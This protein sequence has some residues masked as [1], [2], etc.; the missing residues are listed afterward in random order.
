MAYPMPFYAITRL[1]M[2]NAGFPTIAFR[3]SAEDF[4]LLFLIF[5]ALFALFAARGIFHLYGKILRRKYVLRT[6]EGKAARFGCVP[7]VVAFVIV[8]YGAQFT[9]PWIKAGAG[10]HG[11]WIYAAAIGIIAFFPVVYVVA[12]WFSRRVDISALQTGM[13]P[14]DAV[15]SETKRG[16]EIK[17]TEPA[18]IARIEPGA[19]LLVEI[20]AFYSAE[21][22]YPPRPAAVYGFGHAEPVLERPLRGAWLLEDRLYLAGAHAMAGEGKLPPLLAAVATLREGVEHEFVRRVSLSSVPVTLRPG[23]VRIYGLDGE[24]ALVFDVGVKRERILPGN[25]PGSPV[26]WSGYL[27]AGNAVAREKVEASVVSFRVFPS[28][29]VVIMRPGVNILDVAEGARPVV[30]NTPAPITREPG[31][32]FFKS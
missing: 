13:L 6:P 17:Q 12:W 19:I 20:A 14:E 23:A 10:T 30:P 11:Q 24:G 27:R 29:N 15:R 18:D 1:Q 3:L 8:F 2:I 28:D 5:S 22:V 32:G 4:R 31:P 9:A 26:K 25:L 7:T 21:L 16:E